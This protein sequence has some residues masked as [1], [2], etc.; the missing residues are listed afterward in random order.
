MIESPSRV[1]LGSYFS[2]GRVVGTAETATVIGRAEEAQGSNAISFAGSFPSR[3]GSQPFLLLGLDTALI[4]QRF[5]EA[6]SH[7]LC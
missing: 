1:G 2:Q 7:M 5:G 4:L 6:P 3:S